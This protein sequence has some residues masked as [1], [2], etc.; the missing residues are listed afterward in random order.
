[1]ARETVET[2][3]QDGVRDILTRLRRLEGQVR[4]LQGMVEDGRDCAEVAAQ[5]LAARAALDEIGARILDRELERCLQQGDA[6]P[7]RLRKM[8]RLWLRTSR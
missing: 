4:G 2:D 5:Y 3:E 6:G 8:L 1:M 7:E